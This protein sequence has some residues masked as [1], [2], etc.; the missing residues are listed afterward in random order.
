MDKPIQL[1]IEE[2]KKEII[3]VISEICNRNNI[4]YY[5][6]ERIIDDIHIELKIKKEIELKELETKV[7]NIEGDK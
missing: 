5:F 4:D 6:L 1:K 3:K 2:T 7:N